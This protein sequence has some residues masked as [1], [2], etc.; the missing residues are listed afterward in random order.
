ML[1]AMEN[2]SVLAYDVVPD[3]TGPVVVTIASELGWSLV[4]VHG[5]E[6]AR[7]GRG[8]RPDLG[9]RPR[10]GGA[11]LRRPAAAVRAG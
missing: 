8:D 4:G 9:A 5:L 7:R 6:P 10:R 11:A 2:R 1:L 3:G